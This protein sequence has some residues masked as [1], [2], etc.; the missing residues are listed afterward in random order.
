MPEARAPTVHSYP[1]RGWWLPSRRARLAMLP[2][3]RIAV[4]LWFTFSEV[5]GG[6][7]PGGSYP[8]LP[9]GTYIW[10]W[11]PYNLKWLSFKT[12]FHWP[13]PLQ[14]KLVNYMLSQF[15]VIAAGFS[16][17]IWDWSFS[18]TQPSCRRSCRIS[19]YTNPSSCKHFLPQVMQRGLHLLPLCFAQSVPCGGAL[20]ALRVSGGWTSCLS[21]S[22]LTCW[23]NTCL[24]P[25]C[26]A[27]LWSLFTVSVWSVCP[28]KSL[29]TLNP[30]RGPFLGTVS[31]FFGFSCTAS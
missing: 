12:A 2:S 15:M 24:N 21:T 31:L 26:P 30:W 1:V 22:N 28:L 7:Q 8:T 29:F 13:L 19:I 9:C 18:P 10:F 17:A 14:D 3:A 20:S 16:P 5:L 25:S 27:G 23:V 11:E 4:P 6:F